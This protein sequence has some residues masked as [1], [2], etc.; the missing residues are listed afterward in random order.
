MT[1]EVEIIIKC[2]MEFDVVWSKRDIID[3]VTQALMDGRFD[4][5][6]AKVL[7]VKEEAEIYGNN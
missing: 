3:L 4:C 7:R 2:Y 6:K 1:Q 5:P